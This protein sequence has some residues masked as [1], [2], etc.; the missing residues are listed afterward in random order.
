MFSRT[1]LFT[2]AYYTQTQ[3]R[4]DC[5]YVE[6]PF[7]VLNV[8][9]ITQYLSQSQPIKRYDRSVVFKHFYLHRVS[10]SS[11]FILYIDILIYIFN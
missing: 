7:K 2:S 10:C 9:I 11:F 5:K 6:N 8:C 4:L 3:P 1:D